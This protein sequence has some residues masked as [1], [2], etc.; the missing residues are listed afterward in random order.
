ME[1]IA[2]KNEELNKFAQLL[3]DNGFT[4]IAPKENSTYFHFAINDYIGYVQDNR[5]EGY[6]FSTVHKPCKECGTGFRSIDPDWSNLTVENAI[7]T[8]Q[9]IAPQWAKKIDREAVKKYKDVAD[10]IN[11]WMRKDSRVFEPVT[12]VNA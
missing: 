9:L 6:I 2:T 11:N 1:T 12:T 10:F 7:H 3:R 8:A 5:F 4:I